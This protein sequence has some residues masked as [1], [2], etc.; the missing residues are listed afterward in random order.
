MEMPLKPAK[1]TLRHLSLYYRGADAGQRLEAAGPA[2]RPL[3]GILIEGLPESLCNSAKDGKAPG[4]V[5]M[6]NRTDE[7]WETLENCRQ[8]SACTRRT[9]DN[10]DTAKGYCPQPTVEP[11]WKAPTHTVAKKVIELTR[12][13][14]AQ[15]FS[16]CSQKW[17]AIS[18]RSEIYIDT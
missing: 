6:G 4:A 9:I 18:A 1:R 14:A 13:D 16:R 15:I 17:L 5:P 10:Q 7:T 3:G 11:S 8:R 12:G 2:R